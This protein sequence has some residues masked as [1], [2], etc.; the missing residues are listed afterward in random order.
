[1]NLIFDLTNVDQAALEAFMDEQDKIVLEKQRKWLSKEEFQL[2][3]MEGKYPYYGTIG[4]GYTYI[5]T[6]TSLGNIVRVMNTVTHAE[7]DLTDYS[8]W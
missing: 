3:T 2:Y 7:K 5:I 6:P 8:A 4:G 1:M